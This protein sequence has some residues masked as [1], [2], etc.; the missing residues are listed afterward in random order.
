MRRKVF[1]TIIERILREKNKRRT[2]FHPRAVL[3][4]NEICNQNLKKKICF[5]KNSDFSEVVRSK[6]MKCLFNWDFCIVQI[7]IIFFNFRNDLALVGHPNLRSFL[8]NKKSILF[9]GLFKMLDFTNVQMLSVF[10][11]FFKW[12][13]P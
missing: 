2:I 6:L 5:P 10:I 12:F 3:L 1:K 9:F 4:R 13:W 7:Y 11:S 8:K